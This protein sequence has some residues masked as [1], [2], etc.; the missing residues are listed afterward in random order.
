MALQD[1]PFNSEIIDQLEEM[2]EL[3]GV[4]PANETESHHPSP[5][6]CCFDSSLD[7]ATR[8]QVAFQS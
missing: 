2:G 3:A 8:H 6:M 4:C 7:G 1:H 5:L